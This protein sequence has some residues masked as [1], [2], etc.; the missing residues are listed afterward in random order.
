MAPWILDTQSH[1][2]YPSSFWVFVLFCFLLGNYFPTEK[3]SK[4][5]SFTIQMN[6]YLYEIYAEKSKYILFLHVF[7]K[8]N[9]LTFH[10]MR[11]VFEI[12]H[13]DITYMRFNTVRMVCAVSM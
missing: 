3:Y 6:K 1:L 5:E 13:V 12:L 8:G 10:L 4:L 7:Q 2:F 11:R 9:S